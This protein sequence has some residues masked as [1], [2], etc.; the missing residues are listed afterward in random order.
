MASDDYLTVSIHARYGKKSI[1]E[2]QGLSFPSGSV[3]GILGRN[4]AGKTTLLKCITGLFPIAEIQWTKE[5]R[6][7]ALIETP[8]FRESWTG[9]Q[10]LEYQIRL[11]KTNSDIN[12][13]IQQTGIQAFVDQPVH[14]Y[15]LGQ[16]QRLGIA[17]ALVHQPECLILDEPTN[18]LDPQGIV[19]IRLLIAAL[20]QQGTNIILSSHLLGEIQECCTH[21]VVLHNH[22]IQYAGP[23]NEYFTKGILIQATSPTALE[24]WLHT[25]Q[26]TFTRH[27]QGFLIEEDIP[28][29]SINQMCFD[30]GIVLTHLST[31]QGS[32]EDSFVKE[33]SD[34]YTP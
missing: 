15:S 18:G 21:L 32:I 10:H 34:A 11:Y 25:K 7:G 14:T 24:D 19:D 16:K 26:W 22:T 2:C 4:G 17:R 6:I 12:K 9:R 13:A 31:Y 3:V 30:S 23:L 20:H 29:H 1:V 5:M 27:P 28:T 8:C 33:T